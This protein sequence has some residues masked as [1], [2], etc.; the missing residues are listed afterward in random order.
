MQGHQKRN[1][2]WGKVHLHV[3]VV[4]QAPLRLCKLPITARRSAVGFRQLPITTA[5]SS[6]RTK[7]ANERDR[8][9]CLWVR[10]RAVP[11]RLR[12]LPDL[13]VS[14]CWPRSFSNIK[15]PRS[16]FVRYS[17]LPSTFDLS[18]RSSAVEDAARDR[19]TSTC[20]FINLNNYVLTW[21]ATA[22]FAFFLHDGQTF[23]GAGRLGQLQGAYLGLVHG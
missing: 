6:T 2:A 7:R 18:F 23:K 21:A 8:G 22:L 20:I 14:F 4:L 15:Y 3:N 17:T 5:A 19:T 13:A 11:D 1:A 16:C 12:F 10:W 9:L